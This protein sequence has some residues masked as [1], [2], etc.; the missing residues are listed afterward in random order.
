MLKKPPSAN[1]TPLHQCYQIKLFTRVP[2]LFNLFIRVS[3][4]FNLFIQR[5]NTSGFLPSAKLKQQF[6]PPWESIDSCH[7]QLAKTKKQDSSLFPITASRRLNTH[8]FYYLSSCL[9]ASSFSD[10][11]AAHCIHSLIARNWFVNEVV[12]AYERKTTEKQ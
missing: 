10:Y 9:L 6:Y 11:I 1:H 5:S 2:L 8:L 4:L 12:S 7:C 3:L